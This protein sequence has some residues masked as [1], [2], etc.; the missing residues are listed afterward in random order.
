MTDYTKKLKH[1]RNIFFCI[2]SLVWILTPLILFILAMSHLNGSAN[3]LNIFS[4]PIKD[5]LIGFGTTTVLTLAAA[6]IVKDKIRPALSAMSVILATALYGTTG[7]FIIFA[8]EL[9]EE[10]ILHNLYKHYANKYSI[11]KEIDKRE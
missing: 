9:V 3:I 6:I 8:I 7:M 11:N 1:K 10:Y 4:A 2:D 5:I